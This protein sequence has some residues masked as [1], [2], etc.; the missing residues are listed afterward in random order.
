MTDLAHLTAETLR[1]EL[2]KARVK[3]EFLDAI[4]YDNGRTRILESFA[5]RTLIDSVQ[6]AHRGSGT[7]RG[8]SRRLGVSALPVIA[9]R[10]RARTGGG[11]APA[12]E[13]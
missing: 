5:P 3:L 1:A 12:E 11:P 9:R 10:H 8:T 7:S 6:V 2:A 13:L 4:R